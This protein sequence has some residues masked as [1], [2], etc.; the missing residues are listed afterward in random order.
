VYDRFLEVSVT[1]GFKQH[2]IL[3]ALPGVG[4]KVIK[5]LQTLSNVDR[6]QGTCNIM[7]K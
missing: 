2:K 1:L 5:N 6:T 3:Y 4:L 7:K